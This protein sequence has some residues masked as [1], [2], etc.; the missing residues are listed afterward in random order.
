MSIENVYGSAFDD[1]LIGDDGANGLRGMA[2]ED[3]FTGNGGADT[4]MFGV[5]FGVWTEVSGRMPT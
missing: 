4:F 3:T 1:V 2:G 5:S